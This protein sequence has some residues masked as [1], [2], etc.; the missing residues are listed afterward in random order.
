MLGIMYTMVLQDYVTPFP[1]TL[2]QEKP[3]LHT[4]NTVQNGKR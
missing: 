3:Y 2:F 4:V 1:Q